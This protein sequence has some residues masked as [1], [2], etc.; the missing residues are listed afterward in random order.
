MKEAKIL[1]WVAWVAVC[2]AWGMTF[3]AI[4]IMVQSL[5]P[6]LAA[7]LRQGLAGGIFL[8]ACLVLRLEFPGW[9][10]WLALGWAGFLI[11]AVANG[12]AALALREVSGG[13]A[14]LLSATAAFW[15][16]IYEALRRD[17]ERPGFREVAGLVVGFLGLVILLK[18]QGPAAGISVSVLSLLAMACVNGAGYVFLKHHKTEVHPLVSTGIQLGLGGLILTLVALVSG[19][20]FAG[21]AVPRAWFAF[22][23]LVVVGSM[24]GYLSFVYMLKRLPP[25]IAVLYVYINPLVAVGVSWAVVG[26]KVG[27]RF[28]VGATVILIGVALVQDLPNKFLRQYWEGWGS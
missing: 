18:P 17:G 9:R 22:G 14:T 23:F 15:V 24:V 6:M 4:H 21:P 10:D 7:G 16:V 12:T 13:L 3:P 19:E 28:W 11:V 20:R 1:A 27:S 26:E 8:L 25:A 5:P 2:I